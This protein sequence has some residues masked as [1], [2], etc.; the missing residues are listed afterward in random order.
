M[1]L[2]FFKKISF[3]VREKI[4]VALV[5]IVIALFGLNK[6]NYNKLQ[7][8]KNEIVRTE[9]NLKA[10]LD[11]V[12][13]THAKDG[14]VE[15]DKLSFIVKD[16]NELKKINAELAHEV[17][18]TKGKVMAIHKITANLKSDTIPLIVEKPVVKD[19]IAK[20]I[21]KDSTDFSPGNFR[22][23][24]TETFYNT[25]DSTSTSKVTRHEISFTAITGLKKTNTGYEIFVRPD[26]PGLTVTDLRG[27]IIN[28]EFFQTPKTRPPLVSFGLFVGWT[29]YVYDL[30]AKKGVLNLNQVGVGAGLNFNISRIL[31]IK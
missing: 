15:Y 9:H 8:A 10:A 5:I 31:N 6:W 1:N 23:I 11:S 18:I 14:S 3:G 20:I 26:Y 24:E 22:R 30:K 19:G 2:N 27:A 29:P 21:G 17:A 28:K 16:L 12:R 7:E 25:K 13:I 4:I